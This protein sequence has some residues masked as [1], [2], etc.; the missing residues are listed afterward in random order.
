M[1]A[2]LLT[3]KTIIAWLITGLISILMIRKMKENKDER[4]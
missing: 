2:Y 3:F 1:H 4:K